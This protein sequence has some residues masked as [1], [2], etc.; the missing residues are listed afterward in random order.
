[1]AM[2]WTMRFGVFLLTQAAEPSA[3]LFYLN[4]KLELVD[5]NWCRILFRNIGFIGHVA[6]YVNGLYTPSASLLPR[7]RGRATLF[8]LCF[9][10][11][12]I[13]P[14]CNLTA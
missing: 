6:R 14:F 12:L 8:N 5:M 9:I 4:P 7:Y 3:A 1:M 2:P 10:R 11:K 13:V